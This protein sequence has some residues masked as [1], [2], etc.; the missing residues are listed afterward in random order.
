M[1]ISVV[2]PV[3]DRRALVG[4]AIRSVLAQALPPHDIVV[5]DDGSRD[6]VSDA[7]TDDFPGVNVVR[8]DENL[9]VS[10]A[11]NLGVAKAQ[12]DW[13][14]FLDSDDEWLPEKLARQVEILDG[15]SAPLCHTDEIWIRR[16]VR[17]NPCRHHAKRGGDIFLDCLP[18]CVVSPSAALIERAALESLG[19]FDETLPACED[20]DLWLRLAAR[21]PVAYVDTPLVVKHGGHADQ[22][23]SRYWGM[24]RFRVAALEKLLGDATLS[25]E[26]RQAAIATLV[27]K[28]DILASGARK[29]GRWQQADEW[30]ARIDRRRAELVAPGAAA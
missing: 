28:L 13:I 3:H 11:R 10:H 26:H 8:I 16:G 24:D 18:R 27:A 15:H 7:L 17:V 5:V 1:R 25:P 29:R 22:L 14:A 12:G 23:S 19:G 20:Y 4:R 6:G 30:Q 9:G 2:I 21:W